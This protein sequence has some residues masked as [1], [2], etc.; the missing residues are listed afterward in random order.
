MQKI[1]K[2]RGI[3]WNGV[4]AIAQDCERWKA[5]CTPS[6]PTGRRGT[7]KWRQHVHMY[8]NDRT[9]KCLQLQ[10]TQRARC[11]Y[12]LTERHGRMAD[13]L[14]RSRKLLV[15]NLGSE[16]R[17]PDSDFGVRPGTCWRIPCV[18]PR[19]IPSTSIRI[20]HSWLMISGFRRDVDETCALL[21]YYAASCGNCLLTFRENVSV[22]SSRVKSPRRPQV[23]FT[24]HPPIRRCILS[25]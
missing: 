14:L 11:S 24:I 23:P 15:S 16:T 19:R 1:L 20:Q 4:R 10:G 6:T 17:H 5:L 21:G 2:E 3:E 8:I 22:P 12:L 9:S 18:M 7:S 13:R 25:S